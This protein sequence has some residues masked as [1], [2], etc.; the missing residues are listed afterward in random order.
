MTYAQYGTIQ[1]TDFNALAGGNPTTSSG[2]LNAVWATGGTT[3][4][5]LV[6]TPTAFCHVWGVTKTS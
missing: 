6:P 1:A 3:A 4:G 5:L 2:T